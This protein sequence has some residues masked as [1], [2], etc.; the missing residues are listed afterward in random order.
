[1]V[2]KI[3]HWVVTW[4]AFFPPPVEIFSKKSAECSV[5]LYSSPCLRLQWISI[6][7]LLKINVVWINIYKQ[8]KK[9]LTLPWLHNME[10]AVKSAK[11]C[12][13]CRY[14]NYVCVHCTT[15]I[16]RKKP[17]QV[18]LAGDNKMQKIS[19][20]VSVYCTAHWYVLIKFCLKS[21]GF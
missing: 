18:A 15:D 10:L 11:T 6:E 4:G 17:C 21:V 2:Q 9:N 14:Q 20:Q 1:M 5:H 16:C 3:H 13:I 19:L 12:F 8:K 7:T